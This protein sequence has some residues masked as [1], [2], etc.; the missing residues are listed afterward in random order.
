[1][2]VVSWNRGHPVVCG[3]AL[4]VVICLATICGNWDTKAW[5][6]IPKIQMGLG[7]GLLDYYLCRYVRLPTGLYL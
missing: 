4:L 2:N 3:N 5:W 6:N 1:M 7:L